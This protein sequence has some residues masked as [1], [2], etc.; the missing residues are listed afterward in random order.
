MNIAVSVN[1]VIVD[2]VPVILGAAVRMGR[3]SDGMDAL[4]ENASK[5]RL[6]CFSDGLTQMR[7]GAVTES[8][9][10][11]STGIEHHL[12]PRSRMRVGSFADR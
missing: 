5:Q 8:I 4:P 2:D 7:D 12:A 10:R 3:F 1:M 6:G 9:G 11:F